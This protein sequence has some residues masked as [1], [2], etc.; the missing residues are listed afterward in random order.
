MMTMNSEKQIHN[1]FIAYLKRER[2]SYSHHRMDKKSGI[3]VG[4]PDF[5]IIHCGRALLL[6]IKTP[7]GR[8]SEAQR[9]M[10]KQLTLNGN[11]TEVCRSVEE[12]VRAVETWM[13]L[14][15][16]KEIANTEPLRSDTAR[17]EVE[18]VAAPKGLGRAA[19]EPLMEMPSD[20]RRS[21]PI[22]HTDRA[23][24]FIANIGGIQWVCKGSGVA[25]SECERVRKATAADVI[26]LR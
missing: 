13:G 12:C 14:V 15:N 7:K 22:G 1:G 25:G 9:E 3:A 21:T 8:L 17:S 26:N 6:E 24:T 23:T 19:N 4:F 11:I 5:C 18:G 20:R 16:G 10:I 2:L